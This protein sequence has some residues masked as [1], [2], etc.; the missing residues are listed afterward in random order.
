MLEWGWFMDIYGINLTLSVPSSID[1]SPIF[2]P[3]VWKKQSSTEMPELQTILG[4]G[5]LHASDESPW[6]VFHLF[7]AEATPTDAGAGFVSHGGILSRHQSSPPW[8]FQCRMM[9]SGNL[10]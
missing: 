1:G 6:R 4:R 2:F 9:P 7:L 10:T 8:W 3:K 5:F